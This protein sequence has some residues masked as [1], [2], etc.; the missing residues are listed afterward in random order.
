MRFI[1]SAIVTL[2]V[3]SG[4]ARANV[5]TTGADAIEGCRLISRLKLPNGFANS[6]RMGEC[7][8]MLST[9]WLVGRDLEKSSRYCV[10]T[11]ATTQQMAKGF[12]QFLDAHPERQHELA[13]LLAI[14]LFR[15]TW[16]CKD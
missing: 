10:P 16:P 3:S 14:E 5:E 8:G 15:S 1:W 6:L 7:S 13:S 2:V 9:L 12:V 4:E 11:S